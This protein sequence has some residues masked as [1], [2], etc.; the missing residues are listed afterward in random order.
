M[1]F[2]PP[3]PEGANAFVGGDRSLTADMHRAAQEEALDVFFK[4]VA[5]TPPRSTP[6]N[7]RARKALGAK[8]GRLAALLYKTYTDLATLQY[9]AVADEYWMAEPPS[10]ERFGRWFNEVRVLRQLP[11]EMKVTDEELR[12]VYD[13]LLGVPTGATEIAAYIRDLKAK[14]GGGRV[15]ELA[16]YTRE[17]KAKQGG[18]RATRL[19]KG[20][21]GAAR[22]APTDG[23]GA[24]ASFVHT[25]L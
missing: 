5:S 10:L 18:G 3:T 14:Q 7:V 9:N 21:E 1:A 25:C 13:A 4:H 17:L 23:G 8:A 12:L 6:D 20:G 24:A 2:E 11:P 19:A 16:A 15:A 22:P